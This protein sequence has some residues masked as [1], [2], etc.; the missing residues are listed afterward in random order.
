MREKYQISFSLDF[1]LLIAKY[2]GSDSPPSS[3]MICE[4]PKLYDVTIRCA[5]MF[6]IK[7]KYRIF[8]FIV[9]IHAI[10][11]VI[12][13]QTALKSLYIIHGR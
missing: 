4:R 6:A 13:V 12:F 11:I 8:N 10:V 2:L 7:M 5:K 9:R 1:G 3:V